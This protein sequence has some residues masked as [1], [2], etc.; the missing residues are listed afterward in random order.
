MDLDS[1]LDRYLRNP[2]VARWLFC[3][4]DIRTVTP[5]AMAGSFVYA[6]GWGMYP[7]G[8]P[9]TMNI[10][11]MLIV[12]SQTGNF[13]LGVIWG[14]SQPHVFAKTPLMLNKKPIT[15]RFAVDFSTK[16]ALEFMEFAAFDDGKIVVMFRQF[17]HTLDLSLPCVACAR[18]HAASNVEQTLGPVLM[19]ADLFEAACCPRCGQVG[20]ACR[21]SFDSY[22]PNAAVR[23]S[24]YTWNQYSTAFMRKARVGTIKLRMTATL[25]VVGELRIVDDE[26]P[27]LNV[28]QK[29]DTEYMNLL[30]RKAVLGL[31]ITVIMPRADTL[32][33]AKAV[34]S[35]FIDLH[36]S[37]VTRKRIL[38]IG[39]EQPEQ[40]LPMPM[41][42]TATLD[43]TQAQS[44][45]AEGL[46]PTS[47][48]ST[49]E[50]VDDFLA[51][52][53]DMFT[54]TSPRHPDVVF[55]EDTAV[56]ESAIPMPELP[57]VDDSFDLFGKAEPEVTADLLMNPNMTIASTTNIAGQPAASK[58]DIVDS[59]IVDSIEQILSPPGSQTQ[60]A[61]V[62]PLFQNE[63]PPEMLTNATNAT[64]G[65]N[66]T[67]GTDALW[68][69]S[70]SSENSNRE[71]P[72]QEGPGIQIGSDAK[73]KKTTAKRT[74]PQAVGDVDDSEKKHS[75]TYANCSSKFKMRGDLLRHIKI[76][77]EG[78]KMYT[79]ETCGKKFGH[80]GHLN[81]HI[82]SVHLQ[83][84]PFK[85]K[86]CGFRFFQQS[87]LQSHIGHIHD[88]KKAF[89]CKEC[90]Y[91]APS[92]NALKNHTDDV[93]SIAQQADML[94]CPFTDCESTFAFDSDL[95]IHI[96]TTHS[97]ATNIVAGLSQVSPLR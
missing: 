58:A 55:A 94:G 46:G 89:S 79:C 11:D 31:G 68:S 1:A 65:S 44:F 72:L 38:E 36:N 69:S 88:Q 17:I 87:H 41:P 23:K 34:E 29:G 16:E 14:L 62:Q 48:D 74:K 90:G 26:V 64:G 77:H 8:A 78:K 3:K 95:N 43:L 9:R 57:E 59:D 12:T 85:C 30:R 42:P 52:F 45:I 4:D 21:C 6:I 40:A 15:R 47:A 35:D 60:T 66:A 5:E 18:L 70:V 91:R 24:T 33:M 92:Q 28:L 82:Q 19:R 2:D 25:P 97:I 27:V 80:S 83:H 81:R 20:K 13:V 32:V 54:A 56:E 67:V 37:Y 96:L 84:R 39:E 93:H 75:C 22:A 10:E 53:P 76:V 61:P 86:F 63:L 51:I 73:R 71:L 7:P 50:S 49:I